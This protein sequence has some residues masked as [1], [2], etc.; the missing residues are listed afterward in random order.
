MT[1]GSD[2]LDRDH[3]AVGAR[4][5]GQLTDAL[6]TGYQLTSAGGQGDQVMD[7]LKVKDRILE[8]ISMSVKKVTFIS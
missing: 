7:Q 4:N 8:N 6:S 3:S 1:V 2:L 5:S